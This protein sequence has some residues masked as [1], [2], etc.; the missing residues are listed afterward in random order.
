MSDVQ[1]VVV[2]TEDPKVTRSVNQVVEAESESQLEVHCCPLAQAVAR[3]DE[4]EVSA[5][6]VDID[7]GPTEMLD[8]L[9]ELAERA[10]T[11]E[12]FVVA[13]VVQ[14]ELVLKAMRMGARDFLEK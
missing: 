3:L 1:L 2:V 10:Q 13:S 5:L 9:Q 12:F 6:F 8:K 14:S 7:P 4:S 11:K